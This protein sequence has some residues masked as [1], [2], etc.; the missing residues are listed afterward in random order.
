MGSLHPLDHP[1]RVREWIEW[2][3]DHGWTE[4][5]AYQ[6]ED[7]LGELEQLG[8]EVAYTS[9]PMG[10]RSIYPVVLIE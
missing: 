6:V 3:I 5:G 7:G 2:A 4:G 10:T 1:T 9:P 8:Y